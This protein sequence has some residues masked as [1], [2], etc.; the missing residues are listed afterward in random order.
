[1]GGVAALGP[2]LFPGW[3]D[4]AKCRARCF[5]CQAAWEAHDYTH[6]TIP[7]TQKKAPALGRGS[8]HRLHLP[9][10]LLAT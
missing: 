9:D 4:S 2:Q 3:E 1:M 7:Q 8:L 10:R 5:Q 6:S